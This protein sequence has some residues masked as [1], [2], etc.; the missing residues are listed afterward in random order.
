MRIVVMAEGA[1]ELKGAAGTTPAPGERLTE[2]ALGPAHLLVRRVLLERAAR[3][4]SSLAF[5]APLRVN[6]RV[7]RGS[8]LKDRT[9]LRRLLSWANPSLQPDLA[10]VLV[11]ADGDRQCATTLQGYTGGLGVAPVLGVAV[12]E[13]ES[14]LVADHPGASRALGRPLHAPQA[15]EDLNRRE[16][17]GILQSWMDSSQERAQRKALVLTLDLG[18]VERT[19]RSFA[20]F[21]KALQTTS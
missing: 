9:S 4:P 14:W 13:F 20:S 1:W 15:P 6:G 5:E 12:Q 7:A 19:C 16:A 3:P 10:V 21:S 8:D 18:R 2:D 17:K 11:D